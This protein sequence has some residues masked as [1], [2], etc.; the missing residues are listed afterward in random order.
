MVIM[1]MGLVVLGEGEKVMDTCRWS[2]KPDFMP[3]H[4]PYD[5]AERLSNSYVSSFI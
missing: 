4:C 5:A 1:A 3:R 2:T